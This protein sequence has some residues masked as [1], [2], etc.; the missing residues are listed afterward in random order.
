[1]SN[2]P[3]PHTPTFRFGD[4]PNHTFTFADGWVETSSPPVGA[5][6]RRESLPTGMTAPRPSSSSS[7]G[8]ARPRTPTFRFGDVSSNHDFTF[9]DG[10]VETSS[11]PPG[12]GELRDA[13]PTTGPRPSSSS[14]TGIARPPTPSFRFGDASDH[15]FSFADGWVE[16]LPSPGGLRESLPTTGPR[17]SSPSGTAT[18][19]PHLLLPGQLEDNN[20][21]P[22]ARSGNPLAVH[23]FGQQTPAEFSLRILHNASPSPLLRP[24][25]HRTASGG[26][27]N[28][29]QFPALAPSAQLAQKLLAAP[30][31]EPREKP[32]ENL[33]LA[34]SHARSQSRASGISIVSDLDEGT[35]ATPYDVRNESAPAH[36]FFTPEFQSALRA[37]AGI[38]RDTLAELERLG[39]LVRG[40]R[41]LEKLLDDAVRLCSFQGSD[42]KT[43]AVLG[44]SGEGRTWVLLPWVRTIT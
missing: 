5:G 17:P 21:D 22:S 27:T 29:A 2:D 10:W 33:A 28:S 7:T 14:E 44:D 34:P 11:P 18:A 32:Q 13:L 23:E 19:H 42:T 16:T 8:I 25:H 43:I 37:G 9:A 3:R 12:V 38:A 6:D 26:G 36:R 40:E 20:Q 15:I 35:S 24:S 39:G 41:E 31:P 4:A 30:P 1:M